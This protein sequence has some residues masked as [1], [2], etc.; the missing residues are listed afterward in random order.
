MGIYN[1]WWAKIYFFETFPNLL[2]YTVAG[3]GGGVD[4]AGYCLLRS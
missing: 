2:L 4:F 3:V 1:Y